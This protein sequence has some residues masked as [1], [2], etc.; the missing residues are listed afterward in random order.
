MNKQSQYIRFQPWLKASAT[1]EQGN[2]RSTMEDR[3]MMSKLEYRKKTYYVFLLCDGHQSDYVA[4]FIQKN[5][6]NI[7]EHWITEFKGR[8]IRDVITNTFVEIDKKVAG[9]SSGSTAS[10]LLIIDSPMD[11]WLANVGDSTIYGIIESGSKENVKIRKLSVDHNVNHKS[12]RQR[13]VNGKQHTIED[14]YVV[15]QEGH[16]LAMTRALGDSDFGDLISPEP[17]IKRIKSPYTIFALASDGIWDVM[18]GKALW[19]KLYPPKERKAWRESAFRVN[20]WR[21][22]EFDQHDNTSLILV[23]VNYKE[24]E[25]NLNGKTIDEKKTE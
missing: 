21:N 9:S 17:S 12:E 4:D 1:L 22:K 23:Y 11:I 10:L 16:M 6:M 7:F 5:F 14:G 18:N 2:K 3:V 19:E 24:Y 25:K 15:T 20:S 13:I 8:K